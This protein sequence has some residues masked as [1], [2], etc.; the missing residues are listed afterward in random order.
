VLRPI[1]G[2]H[3]Q[4]LHAVWS[5][6]GVRRFLWDD[7]IITIE[8]TRAAIEKSQRMFGEHAFGLWGVWPTASPNLIGFCG[9]WPFREPPNLELL[10]GIAESLWGQGY[11][12]EVAQ[13]VMTYCKTS[14]LQPLAS[15][16][17]PPVS[18]L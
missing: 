5:S 13:A 6:P 3:A 10:Y 17:Q 8:R 9:L 18:S 12:T 14:N 2:E 1:T 7:E 4:Q 16:L 11:A 15:S